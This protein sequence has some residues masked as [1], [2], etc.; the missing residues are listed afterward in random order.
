MKKFYLRNGKEVQLGDTICKTKEINH[1]RLGKMKF[2]EAILVTDDVIPTL[3]KEGIIKEIIIKENI[4]KERKAEEAKETKTSVA[5]S[6]SEVPMDLEYYIQKIA[7]RM[8]WHI[9][10]VYNYLNNLDSIFPAAAFS[11]VLREIAIELDKKYKDHINNSPRIYVISATDGRIT[12]L[13][14]AHIKNYRNFAAFRSVSD[15]K[16]AC[17]IVRDILKD[18]FKSGK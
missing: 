12:E 16:I 5:N 14:K 9:D 7:N 3:I 18:M 17:S 2:K 1:P 13:N 8:N 6:S 10:K 11:V 15:A 4:I